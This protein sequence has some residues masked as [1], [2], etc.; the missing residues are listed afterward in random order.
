M[1]LLS[2][3]SYTIFKIKVNINN[4]WNIHILRNEE[5]VLN[6]NVRYDELSR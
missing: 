5:E 2:I 4:E 6:V 1:S 3:L